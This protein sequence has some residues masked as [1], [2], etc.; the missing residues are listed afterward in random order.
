MSPRAGARARRTG[1]RTCAP[2]RRRAARP[3]PPDSRARACASPR[4]RARAPAAAPRRR[5]PDPRSWRADRPPTR[6]TGRAARHCGSRSSIVCVMRQMPLAVRR[7]RATSASGS[8]PTTRPCGNPHVRVDDHVL[9]PHAAA[10][11]DVGQDHRILDAAVRMQMNA[12]EQQRMAQRRA[13]DDAAAGDERRDPDA[14]PAVHVV[15]ELGRRRDLRIG[16]DRPVAVVEIELRDDV[17]QVDVRL[18]IGVERADVAPVGHRLVG[19]ASRTIA[20]TGA[21]LPCR[22]ARGTE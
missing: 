6:R 20:R 16:P 21:R 5:R 3:A 18:P 11:V 1:W 14:A 12:G 13:G 15:D 9:E 22:S 4:P 2:S 8:S 17:G 19:R 10:D 7:K